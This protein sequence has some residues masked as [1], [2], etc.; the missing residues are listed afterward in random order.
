MGKA[1]E[2]A[3]Q[4]GNVAKNVRNQ[5]REFKAAEKAAGKLGY[6]E[7]V[8]ALEGLNA[9]ADLTPAEKMLRRQFS[10]SVG[11]AEHNA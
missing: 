1:L 8:K 11:N 2:V 4:I 10:E 9:K 7:A 6:D 3:K 5:A